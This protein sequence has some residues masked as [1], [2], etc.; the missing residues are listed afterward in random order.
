LTYILFNVIT[1]R[2]I[3]FLL[4]RVGGDTRICDATATP[5]YDGRC[6]PEQ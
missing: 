6:P 2:K 3:L 5:D 1:V 4:L